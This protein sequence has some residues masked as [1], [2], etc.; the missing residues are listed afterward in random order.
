MLLVSSLVSALFGFWENEQRKAT[1]EGLPP[2]ITYDM[3]V[4]ALECQEEYGHPAGCTLAQIIVESGKG[5]T[6]SLLAT[7][8]RNLFGRGKVE[9][10]DP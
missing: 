3:V 8:D 4:A 5:E 10:V 1:V 7:R 9:L 6:M 2:Y